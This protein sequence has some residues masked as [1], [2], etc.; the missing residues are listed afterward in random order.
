MELVLCYPVLSIG[1]AQKLLVTLATSLHERGVIQKVILFDF[2]GG[3]LS[4][5]LQKKNIS[6]AIHDVSSISKFSFSEKP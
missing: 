3:Y 1:G 6:L 2:E 4:A 5:E